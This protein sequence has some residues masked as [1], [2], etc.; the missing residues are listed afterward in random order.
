[1]S[2]KVIDGQYVHH[3][4]PN[5]RYA[6]VGHPCKRCVLHYNNKDF[7]GKDD[8]DVAEFLGTGVVI[9][10]TNGEYC[11]VTYEND[12]FA[13]RAGQLIWHRDIDEMFGCHD[14]MELHTYGDVLKVTNCDVLGPMYF[15]FEGA[16]IDGK[17]EFIDDTSRMC[18]VFGV[19]DE[20]LVSGRERHPD[21]YKMIEE[22]VGDKDTYCTSYHILGPDET[23]AVVAVGSQL[24]IKRTY[25]GNVIKKVVDGIIPDKKIKMCLPNYFGDSMTFNLIYE[26]ETDSSIRILFID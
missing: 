17:P 6:V 22:F 9:N 10:H 14:Y 1:M 23:I 25:K 16:K 11:F 4:Y 12:L 7:D 3:N 8:F 5:G 21:H 19:D 20:H 24:C 26:D 2:F 13:Y 18:M 15:S